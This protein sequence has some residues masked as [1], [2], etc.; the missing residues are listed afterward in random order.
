MWLVISLGYGIF[1]TK[2][3]NPKEFLLEYAGELLSSA[4]GDKR[5]NLKSSEGSFLFFYNDKW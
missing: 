1:T 3:I 2:D 4:E 5:M